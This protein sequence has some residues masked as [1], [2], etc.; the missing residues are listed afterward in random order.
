MNFPTKP[1]QLVIP[2]QKDRFVLREPFKLPFPLGYVDKKTNTREE[3]KELPKGT[4][5]RIDGVNINKVLKRDGRRV[6]FVVMIVPDLPGL[7]MVR[8]G[9]TNSFGSSFRLTPDEV[10]SLVLEEVEGMP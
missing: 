7:T 10:R 8:Y 2:T 5:I 9:G 6:G 4:V 1:V 3:I